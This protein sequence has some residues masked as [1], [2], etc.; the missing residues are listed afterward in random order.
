MHS[1]FIAGLF[2]V[3]KIWKQ[4][5][6][7]SVDDLMKQLWDISTM[8]YYSALKKKKR[9]KVYSLQQHGWTMDYAKQVSQRK[10]NMI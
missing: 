3:A 8:E 2:T 1:M 4:P 9:R 5:K 6:G 10:T 7:P